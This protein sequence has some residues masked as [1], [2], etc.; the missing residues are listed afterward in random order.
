[1]ERNVHLSQPQMKRDPFHDV[2]ETCFAG[3]TPSMSVLLRSTDGRA[4]NSSPVYT[5]SEQVRLSLT[6]LRI[7]HVSA[8]IV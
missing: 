1:M 5:R 3:S 8:L 2:L 7:C 4:T 6:L